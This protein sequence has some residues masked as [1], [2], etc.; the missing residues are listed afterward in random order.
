MERSARQ[1]PRTLLAAS[2]S[3]LALAAAWSGGTAESNAAARAGASSLDRCAAALVHYRPYKGVQAGLAQLPWIAASPASTGLVGHLFYYDRL[4]VWK[5]KRLARLRIYSGGQ[6]PDG[7]I[8]MKILWELRRGNTMVLRV[9]GKR[10][11][12]P[13]A[14]SQQLG[15]AASSPTQFPSIIDV[16]TPGCW[17]LTLKTDKTAGQVAVLALPGKTG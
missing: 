14:F 13:G 8:S 4:N 3:A 17:R 2:S 16:P 11:D 6:S 10:L 15:S 1:R 12:G 5:Q 7:R 9:Q